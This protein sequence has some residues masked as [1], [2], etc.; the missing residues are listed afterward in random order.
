MNAKE[1]IGQIVQEEFDMP[2]QFWKV[3]SNSREYVYPKKV[4]IYLMRKL[5]RST[6]IEIGRFAGYA[7]H[8]SIIHHIYNCEEL[9]RQFDD[10]KIKVLI[11]RKN[12]DSALKQMLSKKELELLNLNYT[13]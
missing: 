2:K 3:K 5:T 6:L 11:C 10:F 8:S 13:I 9:M 12:A 7:D 1:I 4:M